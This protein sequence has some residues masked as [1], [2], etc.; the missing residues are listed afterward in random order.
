M[1][2]I[3]ALTELTSLASND[4]LLV[5][6]SSANIAKK[7]SVANAFGIPDL[8]WTA[9][10]ETWTYASAT[11]ITVP[12]NATT[13]Y[14]KG[15]LVKIT[16]VTGGTKYGT[17]VNVAS[18]LLTIKWKSGATLANE[19]ITS[20]QYTSLATPLGSEKLEVDSIG[21]SFVKAVTTGNQSISNTSGTEA[22]VVLSS[23]EINSDTNNFSLSSN[24]IT[25]ATAGVYLIIGEV[26]NQDTQNFFTVITLN[27]TTVG[28]LSFRGT[29]S[30][31]RGY[32]TSNGS[33]LLNL[34][35]GDVI[36]IRYQNR[37]YATSITYAHLDLI[38][39]S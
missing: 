36:K 31:S 8:G 19:T 23:T 35:A 13:K 20:P 14:G 28:Q 15:M 1:G 17:I 2:R 29:T 39:L 37:D 4:Y 5:L 11:T 12:S 26:R 6:D 21:N 18:T 33:V 34:A 25:V 32:Q 30:T 16:Q 24:G 7:I 10:G 3:S 22:D 9:S 38:R 27:G